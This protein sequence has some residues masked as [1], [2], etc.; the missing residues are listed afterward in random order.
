MLQKLQ[1]SLV[2]Y[3]ASSSQKV[4]PDPS[5]VRLTMI[6]IKHTILKSS[7]L[8]RKMTLSNPQCKLD[9]EIQVGRAWDI[10]MVGEAEALL[11]ATSVRRLE[12]M[13]AVLGLSITETIQSLSVSLDNSNNSISIIMD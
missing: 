4:S 7:S 2:A 3:P 1:V 5:T 8:R 11:A 10:L 6:L 12:L 13:P 9:T